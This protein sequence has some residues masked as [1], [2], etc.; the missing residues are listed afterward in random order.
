MGRAQ[1]ALQDA[2][3]CIRYCP[4]WLKGY[5]R[6]SAALIS[7]GRFEDALSTLITCIYVMKVTPNGWSLKSTSRAHVMN[8][9]VK[10]VQKIFSQVTAS[11]A[12]TTTMKRH[13][14]TRG[15]LQFCPYSRSRRRNM[16]RHSQIK[17]RPCP[18]TFSRGIFDWNDSESDS[19]GDEDDRHYDHTSSDIYFP[20]SMKEVTG[21]CWSW[22]ASRGRYTLRSR[23]QCA[24][25]SIDP[26]TAQMDNLCARMKRLLRTA[27]QELKLF[28]QR[29]KSP[30]LNAHSVADR[31]VDPT[32]VA[33]IDME[34]SLCYRLF[35]QPVSTGCGHTF[36]RSCLER[37]LDHNP[38]CP[39]CKTSL[40]AY[41]ANRAH[42]ATEF[43]EVLLLQYLPGE[44]SERKSQHHQ[45]LNSLLL[46]DCETKCDMDV[47]IFVCTMAYP[48]IPCPLH[49]FEPR[50][51][52]MIRRCVENGSNRFGMCCY[53]TDGENNY[54]DIGTLLHIR[55]VQYFAD[56]RSVVYTMG[57][58]R[59][60]VLHKSVVDGYNAGRI[61]LLKDNPVPDTDAEGPFH[62][63]APN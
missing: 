23:Q 55:N 9:V 49:V 21:S 50:Y 29:L 59:F 11:S 45:E 54:G 24:A 18:S 57:C 10:V 47:P 12:G 35:F 13:G 20:S 39:L 26:F 5:F 37:C 6:K 33:S 32:L 36:C 1:E 44:H 56:G 48:T 46:D 16:R 38:S 3:G 27:N 42:A 43:L 62:C 4:K 25:S 19:S 41:L 28:E 53:L 17:R 58:R 22:K 30:Q 61:E 40:E 51:R 14:A 7:L 8:E 2:D 60:R 34:C 31:R 15:S 52:L 63:S